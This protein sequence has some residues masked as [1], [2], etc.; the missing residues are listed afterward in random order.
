MLSNPYNWYSLS[1]VTPKNSLKDVT[2]VTGNQITLNDFRGTK[3]INLIH[4]LSH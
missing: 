3:T 4:N 2:S 1:L